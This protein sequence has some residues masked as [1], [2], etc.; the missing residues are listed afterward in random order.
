MRSASYRRGLWYIALNDEP[1]E[2]DA[3]QMQGF[4]SVHLL[5]ELFGVSTERVARDVVRYRRKHEKEEAKAGRA[6]RPGDLA[7]GDWSRG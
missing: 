5:S 2:M 3:E 7:P 1:T 4:A 6:A